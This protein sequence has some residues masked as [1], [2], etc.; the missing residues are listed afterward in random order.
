[1]KKIIL[2]F[3]IPFS[4]FGQYTSIPDN[5]FELA[6]LNYGYDF[7]VD[8]FVETAAIDTV[9]ILYI[10]GE[11]ISELTGIEDFL[12]LRSLFCYDNNISNLNLSNNAQLFEVICS[13]NN[14]TSI[15]LRNGN[16]QALW[17]FLSLN[18]SNLICIDVEDVSYS[19]YYWSVD[20]WTSFSNNC[21]PN[22][23]NSISKN[24]KLIK[25]L[26]IYGRENNIKPNTP[27]LYIYS[28]GSTQSKINIKE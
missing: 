14:L 7:V 21:L 19:E 15:D 8:G 18:N 10:N 28:D 6:L 13:N 11:N 17:Y 12:S 2:P 4:V 27:L 20:S 1:M 25:V 9:T 22:N 23:I 3:L 24:K 5:N 26:D 16:N